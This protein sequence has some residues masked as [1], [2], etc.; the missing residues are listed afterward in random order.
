MLDQELDIQEHEELAAVDIAALRNRRAELLRELAEVD[1]RLSSYQNHV[2][3]TSARPKPV[4]FCRE[5]F[6][7]MVEA[8]ATRKQMVDFCVNKGVAR[9]TASTQ[10]SLA[11]KKYF[12]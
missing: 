1:D 4:Q 8:G 11:W 10:I 12:G 2:L 7:A 6:D 3:D 9:N 5:V